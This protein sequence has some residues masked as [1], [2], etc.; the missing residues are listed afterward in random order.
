MWARIM[1]DRFKA[2]DPRSM[3]LRF[4]TQTA[5]SSLTAQ[6]PEVN[7]VRTTIQ[8]L[9]AVL[10]GTQSLHTNSMDEALGLPTEQAAR[11]A[12][13]TQQVIAAESGI[14]ETADPLGGSYAIE[15]LT[16]EIE[17]DASEYL[18]KIEAMGGMLR[19]IETGYVQREIQESAYRYQKAIETKEQ[20]VVGVNS[21]QLEE[22]P[23]VQVL[24][25]DPALEQ[26]QIDRVR[27]LRERRDSSKATA[28]LNSLEQ[29]AGT[30]ENL[31]PRILEC[32]EAYATV[33]EISNTLRRVW[34]EYR[35][36]STI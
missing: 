13:R 6:Q 31:L 35:E 17:S 19:A 30:N 1:R 9:A 36:T 10:G 28:V 27:A 4:H 11:V 25:I 16:D 7:V 8:A 32:V 26:E 34:G 20:I 12:L 29:T 3:M 18:K 22:E 15:H 21:F 23:P 14:A 33:G 24:R 5:G 2:R